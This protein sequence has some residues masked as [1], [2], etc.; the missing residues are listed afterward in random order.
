ML[1]SKAIR[2]KAF[3]GLTLLATSLTL[4][5]CGYKPLYGQNGATA[6]TTQHMASVN[7][8]PISDRVGQ[9]MR[10]ALKR[11][12]APKA[13]NIAK[14]Y[15][16]SVSLSESISTLAVEESSFATRANLNL[17]AS[18]QLVR[19][20]DSAILVDGS[21]KTVSSYNILSSDFAT[22]SAKNDAR[23]RAV[24]DLAATLHT[25]LGIYFKGP[26]AVQ[27]PLKTGTGYP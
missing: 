26:G 4:T 13:Q 9:L 10:T 16:L 1:L 24:E 15:E 22:I 17:S 12:L 23:E 27:A 8:K 5:A 19:N 20:A 3:V 2:T 25:R 18:F 11:R 6:Q 7:I 21:L 14:V